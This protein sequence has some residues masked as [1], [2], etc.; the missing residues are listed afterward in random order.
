MKHELETF[1]KQEH[2]TLF[3]TTRA[4]KKLLRMPHHLTRAGFSLPGEGTPERPEALS[5][6]CLCIPYFSGYPENFSAYAAA[7]DYHAYGDVLFSR[8]LPLLRETYPGYHFAGFADKSPYDEVEA[9][10]QAGLG[11][12]GD[13]CLFLTEAYSSFVFLAEIASDLP[14]EQWELPQRQS[15]AL[16]VHC[17]A[18]RAVCPGQKA[19][20]FFCL[21]A[22][23]QKKGEL[24]V[25]EQEILRQNGSVWGCD[26]CQKCCP[27]TRQAA[28]RGT[29]FTQIE[30]FRVNRIERLDRALIEQMN[31]EEFASRAFSWR[32]KQ[33][34]L[35]NLD[36]L[37]PEE[38][39]E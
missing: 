6:F 2:L 26:L 1:L 15:P 14:E 22:L 25:K 23:T 29:L 11:V 37:Y 20:E 13:N 28:E 36:L 31:D 39:G 16:C 30:Y 32:G 27:V 4:D 21:S 18:C 17:G 19:E 24:S 9:H 33:T 10:V 35:R 12:R 5:L 8:F 34:V 7:P 3:G 38:K